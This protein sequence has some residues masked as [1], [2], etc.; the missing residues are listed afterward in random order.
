MIQKI[1]EPGLADLSYSFD[2]LE[3]S[4]LPSDL[5]D[6]LLELSELPELSDFPDFSG[7]PELVLL[8]DLPSLDEPVSLLSLLAGRF[9]PEADL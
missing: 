7:E 2:L 6:E 8:S 9:R 1:R 3:L 4:D 5:V